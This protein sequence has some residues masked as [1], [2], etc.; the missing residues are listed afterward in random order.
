MSQETTPSHRS[1]RQMGP[2]ARKA[3]TS[4]TH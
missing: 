2:R 3:K 4:L 1:L